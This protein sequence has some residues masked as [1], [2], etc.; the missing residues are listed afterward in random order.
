MELCKRYNRALKDLGRKYGLPMIDYYGQI[1][2]LRP[3]D[4]NG[5]LLNRNDVHPSHN[6]L[7]AAEPTLENLKR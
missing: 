1:L 5:T 4:W 3:D 6:R 7:S 2:R